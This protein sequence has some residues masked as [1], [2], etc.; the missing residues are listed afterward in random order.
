MGHG[1]RRAWARDADCCR[2]IGALQRR[3]ER[4]T[5]CQARR[6]NP[7]ETIPSAGGIDDRHGLPAQ[8]QH[9]RAIGCETAGSAERH[10]HCPTGIAL[11]TDRE[12]LCRR[13]DLAAVNQR[14]ATACGLKLRLVEDEIVAMRQQLG[15]K[16]PHRRKIE[17]G[18]GAG[19]P[20]S[21]EA[22]NDESVRHLELRKNDV[23]PAKLQPLG[24]FCGEDGI[25]AG[26]DNDLVLAR[27]INGDH[28]DPRWLVGALPQVRQ[29]DGFGGKK[30]AHRAAVVIRP[31]GASQVHHSTGPSRRDSLIGTLSARKL[32][33][34]GAGN[35]FTRSR[36][37]EDPYDKI[38][39]DAPENENPSFRRIPGHP[40]RRPERQRRL[41]G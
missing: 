19:C 36:M 32:L 20:G 25:R 22:C 14:V 1:A 33:E 39:V 15:G 27:L 11:F 38:A 10:D 30:R 41:A 3:F 16:R 37:P 2:A 7:R 4:Q 18:S 5:G 40:V 28:R 23:T 8:S 12:R 35:R 13:L 21:P 29:I 6:K 24:V 9:A 26:R 31:D 17:N 34:I